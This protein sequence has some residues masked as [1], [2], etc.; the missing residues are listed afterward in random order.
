MRYYLDTHIIIF[1]IFSEF[2]E[3]D[4]VVSEILE[5]PSNRIYAS[6]AAVRETLHLFKTGKI[7]HRSF[8]TARDILK[9][10]RDADIE[11]R[12]VTE[13][14]MLTYA[15]LEI[16]RNHND[17][18]DHILIAQAMCERIPLISSDHKF[19]RY[20]SQGLDLVYNQR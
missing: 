9:G 8:K 12:L 4:A 11:I 13:P 14:H 16:A 20:V 10:I 3:L 2:D 17:P 19:Q 7:S 1:I 15:D 6:I 5:D 18:I